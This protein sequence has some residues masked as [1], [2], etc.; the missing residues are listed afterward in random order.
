M[1]TNREIWRQNV[2]SDLVPGSAKKWYFVLRFL[3]AAAG[4]YLWRWLKNSIKVLIGRNTCFDENGLF[5]RQYVLHLTGLRPIRR[6]T[7][8]GLRSEGAGSQ[9][10]MVMNA[11][12]F[13]RSFG[14]IY[15]H[16][17]F[18]LIQHAERPM[19]EWVAA[20][21]TLFNLGAGEAACEIERPAVV[22][23]SHNFSDLDLCFG[24]RSRGDEL[25]DRFKAL[26]PE[27]RRKYYLNKSPRTTNE[28]TV[29]VHIRRGDVPAD[30]SD[31]F[32]SSET[33][34]RTIIELKS[35]LDTH[36]VKYRICAFSQGNSA[37]FAELSLPGVELFLDVDAV[38]TM[39]ELIE[40]DILIMGKGCF[41]YCAALISNG[42]KI[43]EPVTL[44]G[45]DFLPSWKWRSLSPAESWVPC[46]ADGSFDCTAFEHQLLL[47]IQAKA[48]LQQ[49][50]NQSINLR[51]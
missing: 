26:I 38:W 41:S 5:L 49:S 6:I 42:I 4:S 47:I 44:S 43:F 37:D 36:K 50:C 12:N 35:I 22:N 21:E 15:L 19:E 3:L 17:P 2:N 7:C 30:D 16:T 1:H 51:P 24:W 10:L 14:L 28:V 29:A 32:T 34:L 33:I 18:T 8:T 23:F 9:A 45:N 11:I 25:A 46:R 40:A 27:F 31:Y 48:M 13:A 20:W 39:Q